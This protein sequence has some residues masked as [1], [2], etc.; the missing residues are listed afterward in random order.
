MTSYH[1][2]MRTRN[3][4]P[5]GN[6]CARAY[7]GGEGYREEYASMRTK[8]RA[9]AEKRAARWFADLLAE[10]AIHLPGQVTIS[11]AVDAY[12]ASERFARLAPRSKYAYD[13]YWKVLQE[14][15]PGRLI[16]DLTDDDLRTM[17]RELEERWA[18][19]TVRAMFGAPLSRLFRFALAKGWLAR[20]PLDLV[21]LPPAVRTPAHQRPA[22]S[23]RQ[24][25]TLL[26]KAP[27]VEDRRLWAIFRW[28]GC[29]TVE[30]LTMKGTQI[31]VADGHLRIEGTKNRSAV[32]VMPI[33]PDLE[34][35]LVDLPKGRL[36]GR[37]EGNAQKVLRETGRSLGIVPCY[38][39]MFRRAFI[40]KIRRSDIPSHIWQRWVGHGSD[41]MADHHYDVQDLRF[42]RGLVGG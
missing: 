4:K 26:S 8:D 33:F 1:I 19:N 42:E 38:A 18:P 23:D 21:D 34:P 17:R 15:F 29:R 40:S 10:P 14:R 9:E 13:H 2:Y 16:A 32:R 11:Q 30:G 36:F 24:M 3:G 22:F 25:D 31:H 6:W 35:H 20:N 12:R 7:L 27:S 5:I 28:T 41:A 39:K 37:S